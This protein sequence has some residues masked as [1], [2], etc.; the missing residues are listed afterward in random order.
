MQ[1]WVE[2]NIGVTPDTEEAISNALWEL[3]SNGVIQKEGKVL[4]FTETVVGFLPKD[5]DLDDKVHRIRTLWTDLCRLGLASGDCSIEMHSVPLSDWTT[6]WQQRFAPVHVSDRLIIAPPW[7]ELAPSEAQVVVIEPGMAFGT[8]EHETTQLSLRM[9]EKEIQPGDRL[10]DIGTGSG[11]LSITSVHLGAQTATAI[12]IDEE[13]I[14]NARDNI[15]RNGVSEQV[16]VYTGQIDHPAVSGPYRIIVSNIDIQTLISLLPSFS[17]LLTSAGVLL[18]SGILI[19]EED[20]L[21]SR[22]DAH[23]FLLRERYTQGEWWGG[24]A[25]EMGK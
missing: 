1:D 11:I 10:L 9:L 14:D 23:G 13:T 15:R 24:I 21:V 16:Q 22:L 3:D 7:V 2:I 12:D 25:Q 17:A 18:L 8:G 19:N 20:T 5:V 6:S 4:G